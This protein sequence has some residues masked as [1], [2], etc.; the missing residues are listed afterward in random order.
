MFQ[1]FLK[2]DNCA[3]HAN[4]L[5]EVCARSQYVSI[6]KPLSAR[7]VDADDGHCFYYY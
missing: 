2:T 4:I 1:C 6:P 7:I 3:L 5:E